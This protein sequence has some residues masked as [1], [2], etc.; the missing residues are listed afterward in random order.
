MNILLFIY[1]ETVNKT[2][3][4][5]LNINLIKIILD[6]IHFIIKFFAKY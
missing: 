5:K 2:M 3:R 1:R 6:R 4:N